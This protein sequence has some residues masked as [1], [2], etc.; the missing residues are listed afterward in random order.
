MDKMV[1]PSARSWG[2]SLP[3]RLR[4]TVGVRRWAQIK[5]GDGEVVITNDGATILKTI[6]VQHP[7]AKMV[8]RVLC[9]SRG[10]KGMG[11]TH[12]ALRSVAG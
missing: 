5:K 6:S 10:W 8:R 1:C 9:S 11:L 4:L 3:Y 7:A 2:P 12:T